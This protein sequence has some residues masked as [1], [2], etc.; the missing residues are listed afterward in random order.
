M[1]DKLIDIKFAIAYFKFLG[2]NTRYNMQRLIY[3]CKLYNINI[4]VKYRLGCYGIYSNEISDIIDDLLMDDILKENNGYLDFG[5]NFDN[6]IDTKDILLD[7]NRDIKLILINIFSFYCCEGNYLNLICVSH[8]FYKQQKALYEN[9]DKTEILNKLKKLEYLKNFSDN[10][11]L[12]VI[13]N[14]DIIEKEKEKEC[15]KSK[16]INHV[17]YLI[18]ELDWE[19]D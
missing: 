10:Q 6:Y 12:N 19:K 8:F 5:E 17:S 14:I 16:V 18:N 2:C 11:I 7:D 13:K 4:D 3:M 9:K 1:F 15:V